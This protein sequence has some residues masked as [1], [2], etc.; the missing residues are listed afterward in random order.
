MFE[1]LTNRLQCACVRVCQTQIDT[2]CAYLG[3]IDLQM[4]FYSTYPLSIKRLRTIIRILSRVT[5]SVVSLG[6]RD[7]KRVV[8]TPGIL[9]VFSHTGG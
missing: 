9:D 2:P 4:E 7:L 1:H 8:L 5:V 6:G 3:R